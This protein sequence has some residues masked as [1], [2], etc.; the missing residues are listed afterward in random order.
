MH[1]L[2]LEDDMD[3][4]FALQQ[5]LNTEQISSLWVRKLA[6]V[7]ALTAD[8]TFDCLLLDINLPDGSGFKLLQHVRNQQLQVPIIMITARS[9]LEDRLYGLDG[10]ADDFIIKPFAMAELLSRIRVVTRRYAQ[11]ATTLWTFGELHI[12]PRQHKVTLRGEAV[13]LLRREFQVLL[14]LARQPNTVIAKAVLAQRLEPFAE[15]MAFN[16]LEV[17]VSNLRRKIGAERVRTVRG[18]GYMLVSSC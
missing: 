13:D 12:D 8:H 3:L 5:A 6:D 10:G 16:V 7:P 4:G 18:V 1:I 2:I 14:E 15:A 9:G 11:Q 17:H